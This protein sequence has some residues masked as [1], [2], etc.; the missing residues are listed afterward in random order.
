VKDGRTV[1]SNFHDY[2]VLRMADSALVEVHLVRNLENPTGVGEPAVPP[3]AAAIANAV[4]AAT[5]QRL[6]KLPFRL[7]DLNVAAL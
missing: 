3:L 2:R 4:F 7:T 5:G 1:Q 6:R